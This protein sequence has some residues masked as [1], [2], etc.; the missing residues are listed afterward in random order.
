[1]EIIQSIQSEHV[2]QKLQYNHWEAV[3]AMDRS[4]LRDITSVFKTVNVCCE[5]LSTV[6]TYNE[7][8]DHSLNSKVAL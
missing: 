3:G 8:F 5:I 4:N 7:L 2:K 1:M 6:T